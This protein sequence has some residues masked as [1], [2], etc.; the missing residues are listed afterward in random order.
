MASWSRDGRWLYFVS[1]RTK[2]WQI[3]KMPASGGE[4]IQVTKRG[5]YVAFE[6]ADG[7][8]VYFSR[9]IWQSSIWRVPVEGGEEEKVQDSVLGQAFAVARNGIYFASPNLDGSST[10][11]F[12]SF[13]TG[14]VTTLAT[15]RSS[16]V[17]TPSVG[18][19]LSVSPDERSLLYTQY[20]QASSSLMLVEN[21]E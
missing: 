18:W 19:G 11:Q 17:A 12:H 7:K 3:W 5:G 16:D 20:S 14:K 1:N 21:F 13:A 15:I 4:A 10:I 8:F 2:E 6:S 9:D